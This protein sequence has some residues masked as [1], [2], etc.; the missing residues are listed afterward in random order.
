MS[1]SLS[2]AQTITGWD[3]AEKSRNLRRT[4]VNSSLPIPSP[5]NGCGRC[6][7][8]DSFGVIPTGNSQ[9]LS[10]AQTITRWDYAEKSHKRRTSV[11]SSF[12]IP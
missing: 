11:N 1:Q 9:S 6:W 10:T 4:S 3:Y 7:I 2:T 5:G 8:Q 12:P